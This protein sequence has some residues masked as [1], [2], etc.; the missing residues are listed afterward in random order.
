MEVNFPDG[1]GQLSSP[2]P[3]AAHRRPSD[4]VNA[5]T[6]ISS[7]PHVQQLPWPLPPAVETSVLT[8]NRINR[9][10]SRRHINRSVFEPFPSFILLILE[11]AQNYF[12]S[13]LVE[14][15]SNL[16]GRSCGLYTLDSFCEARE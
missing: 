14:D 12:Q 4:F 2:Q 11:N 6:Q 5:A 13:P 1:V 10:R 15:T 7:L 3:A 16:F 9:P 8:A